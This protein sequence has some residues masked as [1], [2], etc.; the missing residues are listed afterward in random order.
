MGG[1]QT[2][3]K[4]DY[5]A[6]TRSYTLTATGG[7]ETFSPA[8]HVGTDPEPYRS[9]RHVAPASV[10]FF[11]IGTP[12]LGSPRTYRYV[13][14]GY[15]QRNVVAADGGFDIAFY[16]FAYGLPTS[17]SQLPH[18][19]SA[20]YAI[21]LFGFYTNTASTSGSQVIVGDGSINVDFSL[22]QLQLSG[23]A[24]SL[25]LIT[26]AL[27]DRRAPFSGVATIASDGTFSGTL[28]T[29]LTDKFAGRFYGPGAEELG[30][31]FWSDDPANHF[32]GT[33]VGQR[34][35][36]VTPTNF[37]L[38]ELIANQEFPMFRMLYDYNGRLGYTTD[39]SY[40]Y[41]T[42]VNQRDQTITFKQSDRLAGPSSPDY[43]AYRTTSNGSDY[44]L[45][46]AIPGNG[47]SLIQL[48][49]ASFGELSVLAGPAY[50]AHASSGVF[51]PISDNQYF[52]YGL[53]PT[54]GVFSAGSG[55]YSGIV[56]GR[57]VNN[58]DNWSVSGTSA[59]NLNFRDG[60]LTGIL[61]MAGA[62]LTG[63][64]PL[65][66]PDLAIS[67]GVANLGTGELQGQTVLATSAPGYGGLGLFAGQ[68]YGPSGE[69][70]GGIARFEL[71]NI[72]GTSGST[73]VAAVA[74]AKR[75][76]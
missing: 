69:E 75:T 54:V 27:N 1:G 70:L 6:T 60:T 25:N 28:S 18:I 71:Y 62:S 55:S 15:W 58:V 7:S 29:F 23:S 19:G 59:F 37:L 42:D 16:P 49:Y 50:D 24:V 34:A 44:Q 52:I 41:I 65:T 40:A 67:N 64:A 48:H 32:E 30:A 57:A 22:G 13:N 17:I 4:I 53:V 46:L 8:D 36:N 68:L 9:Y 51:R 66:M 3:L 26:G 2:A 33:I 35:S 63:G 43:N 56:T 20:G 21:D 72:G 45:R 14:G 31:A 12:S 5:N 76:P 10:S 61:R 38:T 47:N 74:L 39:G 73:E 11:D